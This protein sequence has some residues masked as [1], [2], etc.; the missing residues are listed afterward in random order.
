MTFAHRERSRGCG[1]LEGGFLR[2]IGVRDLA[3]MFDMPIA[4]P[5]NHGIACQSHSCLHFDNQ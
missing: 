5:S 1:G 4:R 3:V 2:R